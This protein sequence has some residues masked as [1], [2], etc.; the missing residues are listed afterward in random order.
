LVA[1]SKSVAADA[2]AANVS[3][4]SIVGTVK[5]IMAGLGD[6]GAVVRCAHNWKV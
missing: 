1:F 4:A 2:K 6:G 3:R 5:V